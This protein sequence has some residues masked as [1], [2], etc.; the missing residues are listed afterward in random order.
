QYASVMRRSM[1]NEV[2]INEALDGETALGTVFPDTQLGRQLRMVARLINVRSPL[3]MQRQIFFVG[4]GG[5]DTHD[6]QLSDQAE[7]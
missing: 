2:M 6:N 5:F 4:L 1:D 7:Q 3:Q